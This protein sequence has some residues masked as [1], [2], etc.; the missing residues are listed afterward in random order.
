M[1]FLGL[2]LDKQQEDGLLVAASYLYI[3]IATKSK[4]E[5]DWI[6]ITNGNVITF[7]FF[8]EALVI[9]TSFY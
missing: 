2:F 5:K 4:R 1:L 9:M 7:N 8:E 6:K 3:V